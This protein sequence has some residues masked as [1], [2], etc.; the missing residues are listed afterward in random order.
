MAKYL[1]TAIQHK[2]NV[3]TVLK[4]TSSDIH[5]SHVIGLKAE[6]LELIIIRSIW[7]EIYPLNFVF[8]ILFRNSTTLTTLYTM[9]SKPQ[10]SYLSSCPRTLW[11]VN[12][13]TVKDSD[14]SQGSFM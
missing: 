3:E 2:C 5:M 1:S 4:C 7:Q 10:L 12:D 8:K 6:T 9:E 11:T 14:A 13:V